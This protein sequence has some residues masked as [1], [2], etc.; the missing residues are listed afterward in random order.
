MYDLEF[1]NELTLK[2]EEKIIEHF[3]KFFKELIK[4]NNISITDQKIKMVKLK[5]DSDIEKLY[6]NEGFYVI[7]TDYKLNDNKSEFMYKY[8][9]NKYV[10][11][12]YRGE[13]SHR[14]ERITGHL[15]KDKYEGKDINFMTVDGNNGININKEPYCNYS[16][17][18]LMCS[19]QGTNQQIRICVEKAFDLV[20]GKPIYS[21][22]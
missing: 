18:V 15:F 5:N 21:S 12:V 16:W 4:K 13:A 3:E 2:Y 9:D 6:N 19:M 22:R 14:K 10:K 17:Y 8:G 1:I 7:L 11:A 20:F